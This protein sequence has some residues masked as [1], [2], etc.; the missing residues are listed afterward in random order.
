LWNAA[1]LEEDWQAEMWGRDA[2]AEARRERRGQAFLAAAGFAAAAG[3][4][5]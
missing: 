1:S 4:A 3:E 2:E 5:G